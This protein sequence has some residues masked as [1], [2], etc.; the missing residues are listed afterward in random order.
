MKTIKPPCL[1][2]MRELKEVTAAQ[3]FTLIHGQQCYVFEDP[4]LVG[5]LRNTMK[6]YANSA[7]DIMRA[8]EIDLDHTERSIDQLD[9]V[10]TSLSQRFAHEPALSADE[11]LILTL[12]HK[13]GAY[14]GEVLLGSVGGEWKLPP[15]A[16]K[17]IQLRLPNGKECFPSIQIFEQLRQSTVRDLK[18]YFRSCVDAR[19]D[20]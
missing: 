7:V 4:D 19:S 20:R 8:F 11:S 6:D 12:A 17:P 14:V 3:Q 18:A 1:A 5:L 13:L 16:D 15:S 9:A 2:D 10:M